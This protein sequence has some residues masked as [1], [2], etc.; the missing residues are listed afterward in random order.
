MKEVV[1]HS[2]KKERPW[3]NVEWSRSQIMCRTGLGGPGSTKAIKFT[4][5]TYEAAVKAADR[6]V[7]AAKKELDK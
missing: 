4:T 7:V 6:W 2:K 5:A 1:K 3:W